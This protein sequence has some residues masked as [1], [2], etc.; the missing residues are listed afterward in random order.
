MGFHDLGGGIVAEIQ[1]DAV[2]TVLVRTCVA[3]TNRTSLPLVLQFEISAEN[4]G[5]EPALDD[6]SDVPPVWQWVPGGSAALVA[7]RALLPG[8]TCYAPLRAI[9]DAHGSLRVAPI[10]S[11]VR[12][13]PPPLHAALDAW[14]PFALS[15]SIALSPLYSPMALSGSGVGPP[16]ASTTTLQSTLM[17]LPGEE[18]SALCCNTSGLLALPCV[19]ARSLP[20]KLSDSNS[21]PSFPCVSLRPSRQDYRRPCVTHR[22]RL[23]PAPLRASFS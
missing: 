4:D 2:K 11:D 6:E 12:P 22:R 3:I 18:S 10:K 1:S 7:R 14:T 15:D 23:P 8:E 9:R 21:S 17:Q 16:L 20:F 19:E 13:W 5:A